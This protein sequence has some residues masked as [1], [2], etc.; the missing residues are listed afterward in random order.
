M[1]RITVEGTD[2]PSTF[3]ARGARITVERTP[4]VNKLIKKG[5]VRELPSVN[6]TVPDPV[7]VQETMAEVEQYIEQTQDRYVM[8]RRSPSR[9]AAKSEWAAFLDAQQIPYP[10]GAT[11]QVMISTWEAA[12]GGTTD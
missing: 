7:T 3:L 1:P 12:D 8:E 5:Y 10:Q 2:T 9:S 4:F 6:V 11:K